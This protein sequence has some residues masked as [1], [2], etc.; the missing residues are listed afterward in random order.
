M[1]RMQQLAATFLFFTALLLMAVSATLA[2]SLWSEQSNSLYGNQGSSLYGPKSRIFQVGDLLTIN[3][4]EQAQASQQAASSNDKKGS[5]LSG[6]GSGLLN[7]LPQMGASWDSSYN[8]DG[9]T[10][11]GGSLS[12]TITV[13]VK[14]VNPNGT[15]MVEGRQVIK[16]N[17]EEQVL[18][19]SGLART[20]DISP[21]NVI[22]S[23]YIASAVIEYQGKGTIG[24]TQNSG[25]ITKF[26][27]WLF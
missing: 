4:V 9:A 18:K 12:A 25:F 23:S 24:E 15:L 14:E 5:V 3:I 11:R 10:T 2:D 13:Q 22:L 17:G 7:A 16:V 19:I 20:E 6:P 21:Q 1:K 8:G 26:F 27:H